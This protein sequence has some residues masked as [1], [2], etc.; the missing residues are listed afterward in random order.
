MGNGPGL[1]YLC[2]RVQDLERECL[3]ILVHVGG[4]VHLEEARHVPHTSDLVSRWYV[5]SISRCN[6]ESGSSSSSSSTTVGREIEIERVVDLRVKRQDR[7]TL[8]MSRVRVGVRLLP[9]FKCIHVENRNI[10]GFP[11]SQSL[12]AQSDSTQVPAQL[13]L[14]A[15]LVAIGFENVRTTSLHCLQRKT[16]T[17]M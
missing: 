8:S 4:V 3:P 16:N 14:S 9:S 6:C 5:A 12:V 13:I 15:L 2:A 10:R 7:S 11:C 17:T 1:G